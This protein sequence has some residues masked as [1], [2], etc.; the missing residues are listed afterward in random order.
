MDLLN[1]LPVELHWHVQ[2]YVRHPVAQLLLDA[3]EKANSQVKHSILD[4][5][6]PPLIV[7]SLNPPLTFKYTLVHRI[8]YYVGKW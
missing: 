7:N 8:N 1:R 5:V 2:K 4:I 6:Y 3:L